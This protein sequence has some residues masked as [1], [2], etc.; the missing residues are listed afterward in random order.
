[1]VSLA[2]TS[3]AARNCDGDTADVDDVDGV[4]DDDDV[5]DDVEDEEDVA[6]EDTAERAV[7]MARSVCLNNPSTA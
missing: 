2:I 5:A 3:I 6:V 4:D 7:A 1:M